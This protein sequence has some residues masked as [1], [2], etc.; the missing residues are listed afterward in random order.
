MIFPILKL[1]KNYDYQ[2][3]E[4]Y[5]WFMID[6]LLKLWIDSEPNFSS[7]VT[8]KLLDEKKQISLKAEVFSFISYK[9]KNHAVIV[10]SI[11]KKN[12]LSF[13]VQVFDF[14]LNCNYLSEIFRC[15]FKSF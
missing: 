6:I 13:L 4:H 12:L 14:L 5:K 9:L 11:F 8:K 10:K 15:C 2:T 7:Q 3:L 1:W